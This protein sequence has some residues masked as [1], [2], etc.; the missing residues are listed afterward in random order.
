MFSKYLP[1]YVTISA[2][3]RRQW[4]RRFFQLITVIT[5]TILPVILPAEQ[6]RF[7]LSGEGKIR[8]RDVEASADRIT[9]P[10]G[11]E[12]RQG[13]SLRQRLDLSLEVL[14]TDFLNAGG[15]IRISNENSKEVLP[16][17]DFISTK[18]VAGWWFLG[19]HKAP[20]DVA[21]GAYD[22]SFT[23]LTLMR[24]DSNDNPLGASGCACQISVGGISGESLEELQEDYKLEGAR[25]KIEGAL[26]DITTLYARPQVSSE[27]VS[28]TQ[29][30]YGTRGRIILPYVRNFSSLTIGATALRVKD[31]TRSV[32]QATY[33]PLQ[34][35]VIGID[36]N[37]PLLW[38]ISCIAEYA[39]SIRDD[40]LFSKVDRIRRE[41]GIIGG[42]KMISGD[43]I[44]TNLIYLQLDPYFAPLYRAVSYAKNRQGFRFSLTYRKLP[45]FDQR[46]TFSCY[47]KKLTEIKPTWNNIVSE[48]HHSLSDYVVANGA[49]N[50]DLFDNWKLEGS[51]EYRNTQRLDDPATLAA[52][53]I[54]QQDYIASA[55]LTYE[56]TL[57]TK[58]VLKYQLVNHVDPVER[59]DY[60]AH[61]PMLQFYV[62]F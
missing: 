56:F 11:E 10:Y 19:F 30:M 52:E 25:L 3:K 20:I 36:I 6:D 43:N 12:L 61:V 48:W 53:R 44:E 41:N 18:A 34:S 40:N 24:W 16:P 57:L 35:D 4:S 55:K 27:N 51:Y 32:N 37:L 31:D 38:K 23:P 1:A 26:G 46:L 50:C 33:S 62:K 59:N 22:A 13:L 17:P 8:F 39:R 7:A 49:V 14:V 29:Q 45:I 15:A 47:A 42:L 28:F 54:D 60:M 58:I 9:G 21:V 2:S 5:F